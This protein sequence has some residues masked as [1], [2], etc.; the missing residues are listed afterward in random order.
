M[1]PVAAQ[2][3]HLGEQ[4]WVVLQLEDEVHDLVDAVVRELHLVHNAKELHHDKSWSAVDS[5]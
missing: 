5:A 1:N 2:L 3:A 4:R